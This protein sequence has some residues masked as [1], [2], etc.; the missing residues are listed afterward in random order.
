MNQYHRFHL[1]LLQQTYTQLLE[2]FPFNQANLPLLEQEFLDSFLTLIDQ[3][4]NFN[5]GYIENGQSFCTNWVR[6]YSDLTPLLPRDLLWFFSGDC[7]HY[8]PDDEINQFQQL[9][10]MRF[11]AESS[12][13]SFDYPAQRLKLFKLA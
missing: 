5:P 11:E 12:G 7:L 3:F 10:E 1:E 6:G 2:R 4:E 8:M 9:D 13:K